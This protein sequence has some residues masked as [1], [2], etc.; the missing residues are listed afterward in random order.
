LFFPGHKQAQAEA[1]R[2]LQAAEGEKESEQLS[3][4][5]KLKKENL[6]AEVELASSLD[7]KFREGGKH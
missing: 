4:E 2:K 3:V 1:T 5:E 7:K 6:E